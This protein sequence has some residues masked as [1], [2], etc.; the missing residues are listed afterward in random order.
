MFVIA[1]GALFYDAGYYA[2]I[3]FTLCFLSIVLSLRNIFNFTVKMQSAKW[4]MICCAAVVKVSIIDKHVLGITSFSS[5]NYYGLGLFLLLLGL[6]G[7]FQLLKYNDN[8]EYNMNV[9]YAYHID[10]C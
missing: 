2:V 3:I 4:L 7:Y 8:P 10:F 9:H 5:L 6:F 1:L